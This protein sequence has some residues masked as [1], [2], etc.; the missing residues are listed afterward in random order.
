MAEAMGAAKRLCYVP[1]EGSIGKSRATSIHMI[2]NMLTIN[3]Q[4]EYFSY[5]QL[6][7][8][9]LNHAFCNTNS[10]KLLHF[11]LFSNHLQ[12]CAIRCKKPAR[13]CRVRNDASHS[14]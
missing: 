11:A 2:H 9:T 5:H 10:S 3:K 12:G 1:G 13:H 8:K 6:L 7:F 14:T 4:Q